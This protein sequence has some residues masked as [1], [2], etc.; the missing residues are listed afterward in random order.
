[1]DQREFPY[2]PTRT[3]PALRYRELSNI[4]DPIALGL[5]SAKSAS[6]CLER[7]PSPGPT[8][9]EQQAATS[10]MGAEPIL[11]WRTVLSKNEP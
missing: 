9:F 10:N 2:D 4:F 8:I 1:L 7:E 5:F 11:D 3:Q 6:P